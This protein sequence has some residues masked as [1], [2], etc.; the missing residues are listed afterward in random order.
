MWLGLINILITKET[1]SLTC[2]FSHC[3]GVLKVK[4]KV[5]FLNDQLFT[6][7][8]IGFMYQHDW[9]VTFKLQSYLVS[10]ALVQKQN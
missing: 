3:S 9:R 4:Q 7:N 1:T 8:W 6:K 5:Y 2:I 10:L